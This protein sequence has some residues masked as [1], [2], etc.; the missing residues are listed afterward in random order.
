[1]KTKNNSSY[2]VEKRKLL[3]LKNNYRCIKDGAYQA[4]HM[5][6]RALVYF[7]DALLT[8]TEGET[9]KEPFSRVKNKYKWKRW[10]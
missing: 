1:V 3:L 8:M 9:S 7:L 5:K 4:N 10:F 6:S 2:S